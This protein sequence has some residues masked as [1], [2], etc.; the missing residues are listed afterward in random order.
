MIWRVTAYMD[1]E[2]RR[3]TKKAPIGGKGDPVFLGDGNLQVAPGQF[4]PF[5]F[6]IPA[7]TVE[8]AFIAFQDAGEVGAKEFREQL[9]RDVE[10]RRQQAIQSAIMSGSGIKP[11]DLIQ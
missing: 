8:D 9:Q 6:P 2:G 1:D 7:G 5:T 10:A 4:L 11:P 3:V